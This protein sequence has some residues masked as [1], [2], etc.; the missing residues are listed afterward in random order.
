MI[1]S[2]FE[3]LENGGRA[4]VEWFLMIWGALFGSCR[5]LLL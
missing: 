1:F 4:L 2:L 3:R 5:G